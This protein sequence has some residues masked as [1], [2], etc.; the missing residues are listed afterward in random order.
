MLSKNAQQAAFSTIQTPSAAGVWPAASQMQPHGALP[1][2]QQGGEMPFQIVRDD[3][4]AIS[5]DAVI[6]PS[7][8]G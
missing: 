6:V 1:E 3:V 2:C 8:M 4:T 5:A 7:T